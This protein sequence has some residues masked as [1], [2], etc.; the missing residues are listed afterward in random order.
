MLDLLGE[1]DEHRDIE[2]EKSFIYY[3][4]Q[5]IMDPKCL[6]I[7]FDDKDLLKDYSASVCG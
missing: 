6:I 4:G 5:G 3:Y 1:P 7:T 2:G